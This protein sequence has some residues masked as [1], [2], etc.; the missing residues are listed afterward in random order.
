M[1][2]AKKVQNDVGDVTILINNAGIMPH[3]PFL[4]HT[5]EVIQRIMN[6][7]AMAHFWVCNVKENFTCCQFT[8][9][10]VD[11]RSIFAGYDKK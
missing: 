1:Q 10:F 3:R 4:E 6:V 7:N 5:S 8:F 11:A 9:L 2:V